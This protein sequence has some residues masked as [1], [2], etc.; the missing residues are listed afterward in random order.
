[1][2]EGTKQLTNTVAVTR[3]SRV[4]RRAVGHGHPQRCAGILQIREFSV[5][6]QAVQYTAA[7][8]GNDE[9]KGARRRHP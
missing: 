4:P 2:S 8:V 1:M 3:V 7:R 5:L 6:A 9:F